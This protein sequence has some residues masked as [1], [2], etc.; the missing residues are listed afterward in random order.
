MKPYYQKHDG[1]LW[2]WQNNQWVIDVNGSG[3]PPCPCERSP[4]PPRLPPKEVMVFVF[5]SNGTG[6]HGAGSAG[7][8]WRGVMANTW[9][10]DNAFLKAMN[11][12]VGS[13][14][15]IGKFAVFGVARGFQEGREGKSYAIQTVT[16]PGAKR[17]IPLEEIQSQI[18]ELLVFAQQ[19]PE[20]IFMVAPLG[21]GY[22]GYTK[23]EI[24]NLWSWALATMPTNLMFIQPPHSAE[25]DW[26]LRS[27]P[28][29]FK[30]GERSHK[31]EQE[32]LAAMN[33][34]FDVPEKEPSDSDRLKFLLKSL[35]GAK[36]N[37]VCALEFLR[38][39]AEEKYITPS[40]LLKAV[41]HHLKKDRIKH[42]C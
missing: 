11:S 18:E 3:D 21:E 6:F 27:P 36:W 20:W 14:D 16:R 28:S 4:I 31:I 34:L 23:T 40:S 1:Y 42:G 39:N 19:H 7:Y 29:I 33:S 37:E 35:D 9:R 13:P 10:S 32:R 5:G 30:R 15:R 12:P 24:D 22:A 25:E 2:V 26:T 41:D 8:A 17:S 38:P